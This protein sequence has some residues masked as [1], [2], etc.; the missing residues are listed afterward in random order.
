LSLRHDPPKRSFAVSCRRQNCSTLASR[1]ALGQLSAT[2]PKERL[3]V[4]IYL[5]VVT[6]WTIAAG[7]L[8]VS[9][10]DVKGA[11]APLQVIKRVV[12]HPL[13]ALHI[14]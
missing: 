1:I 2:I 3:Y 10:L 6:A 9:S 5:L 7:M 13:A 11:T 8:L 4:R 12:H 14:R